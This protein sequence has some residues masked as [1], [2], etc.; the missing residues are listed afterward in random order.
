MDYSKHSM[1]A[2]QVK[3]ENAM[4]MRD[5]STNAGS[6]QRLIWKEN[7]ADGDVI[8]SCFSFCNFDNVIY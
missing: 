5:G 2:L 3:N 1:V 7:F 8:V 4:E 6:D